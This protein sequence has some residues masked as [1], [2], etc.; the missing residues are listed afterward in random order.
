ML[1]DCQIVSGPAENVIKKLPT[2]FYISDS[3]KCFTLMIVHLH[4]MNN[5]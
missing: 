1:S 2:W 3:P 5:I 4:M